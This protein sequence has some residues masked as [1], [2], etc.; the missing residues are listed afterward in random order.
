MFVCV[1]VCMYMCLYIYIYIYIY[2]YILNKYYIPYV[3]MKINKYY[4]HLNF[5]NYV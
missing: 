2:M 5:T 4:K 1:Y 3:S